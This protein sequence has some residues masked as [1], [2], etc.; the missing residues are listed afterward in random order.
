MTRTS[1]L[2]WSAASGFVVG[3]LTGLGLLAVV[4]L[5][6]NVVPGISERLVD[7]LRMPVILLLLVGV[8]VAAA[9]LGYL[10]GRAKL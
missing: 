7:R 8:P 3:A 5:L 1:I 2:L 4:T 9:V 10:E 6:V